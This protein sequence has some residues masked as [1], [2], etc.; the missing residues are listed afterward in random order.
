MTTQAGTAE[1][2]AI[3]PPSTFNPSSRL[4][5]FKPDDGKPVFSRFVAEDGTIQQPQLPIRSE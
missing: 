4:V 1:V 2:V 3:Y 5:A